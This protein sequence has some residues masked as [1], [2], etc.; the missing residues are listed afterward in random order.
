MWC[1]GGNLHKECPESGKETSV[2]NCCNCSLKGGER[3]RPSSYRGCSHTKEESLRRRSQRSTQKE[4]LERTFSS[5]RTMP[6]KSFAEVLRSNPQQEQQPQQLQ[7]EPAETTAP[8]FT[9][10]AQESGQSAQAPSVT[11]SS[12]DGMFKVATIVQQIMTELNG[13]E[14]SKIV[15]ITRIVLNLMKQNGH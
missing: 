3:S 13:A 8:L 11:T 1:G 4:A 15:A 14:E 9:Q 12:L 2:P 10:K 5:R 7:T 6:G